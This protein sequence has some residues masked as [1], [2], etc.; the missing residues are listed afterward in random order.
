MG[1]GMGTRVGVEEDTK[2]SPPGDDQRAQSDNP[3]LKRHVEARSRTRRHGATRLREFFRP[4]EIYAACRRE[5][6]VPVAREVVSEIDKR[7]K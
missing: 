5:R 1:S 6:R 3:E 2:P 4:V 7:V